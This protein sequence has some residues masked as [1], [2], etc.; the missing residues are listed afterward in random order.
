[1]PPLRKKRRVR[2]EVPPTALHPIAG[3]TLNDLPDC[4]SKKSI[5]F[6]S[7]PED[8]RLDTDQGLK[9]LKLA[10]E[11]LIGCGADFISV[12][13]ANSGMDM[14]RIL[15]DL[16]PLM[17]TISVAQPEGRPGS[18]AQP[19]VRHGYTCTATSISFWS[20]SFSCWARHSHEKGKNIS[21]KV[22]AGYVEFESLSPNDHV[23]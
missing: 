21:F 15:Q 11:E 20:N 10:V 17:E 2:E 3:I 12:T 8:M 22:R 18:V 14:S 1:M 23:K 13:S 16:K 6:I 4:P 19:E 5:G 9:K 7:C